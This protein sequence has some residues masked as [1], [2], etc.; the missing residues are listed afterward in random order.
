MGESAR[1]RPYLVWGACAGGRRGGAGDLDG[2]ALERRRERKQAERAGSR[3]SG[4]RGAVEREPERMDMVPR[5][6]S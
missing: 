6:L 3:L 2:G 5:L 4:E 1:A